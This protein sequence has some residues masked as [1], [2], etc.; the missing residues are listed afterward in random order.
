ML[1]RDARVLHQDVGFSRTTDYQRMD[2]DRVVGSG[3]QADQSSSDGKGSGGRAGQ[4]RWPRTRHGYL[5][6]VLR[7]R[8]FLQDFP[9]LENFATPRS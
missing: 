1:A 5:I 4:K 6:V 7:S 2:T 3:L 9:G 8:G